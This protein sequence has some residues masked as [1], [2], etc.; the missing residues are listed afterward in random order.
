MRVG[1]VLPVD[2]REQS[3]ALLSGNSAGTPI[4]I[5]G[6]GSVETVEISADGITGSPYNGECKDRK[7]R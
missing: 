6:K 1:H 5:D 4:A 7:I 3:F 2:C